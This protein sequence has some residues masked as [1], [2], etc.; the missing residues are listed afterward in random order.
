MIMRRKIP[1]DNNCL[2]SSIGYL[3]EGSLM[4]NI[5]YRLRQ[6]CADVVKA[7]LCPCCPYAHRAFFLQGDP[8]MYCEPVLGMENAK[9]VDWI[10]NPYAA[11]HASPPIVAV[12]VIITTASV[13]WRFTGSTGVGRT[14]S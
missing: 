1:N 14:R 11:L 4:G 13:M 10:C 3:V 12:W 9:Y 5:A 7:S 6:H 8:E 2:F